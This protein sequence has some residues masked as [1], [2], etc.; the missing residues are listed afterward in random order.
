MIKIKN[1]SLKDAKPSDRPHFLICDTFNE[2]YLKEIACFNRAEII[3]YRE[4]LLDRIEPQDKFLLLHQHIDREI[5]IIRSIC[6]KS[7]YPV[8]IIQNLD[9]LITYLSS[10]PNSSL[11][12]FWNQLLKLRQLTKILWI[13]L[14]NKLVN[15]QIPEKRI[16]RIYL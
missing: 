15:P 4:N 10:H 7:D 1:V 11:S 6:C 2:L 13:I 3:D 14:P 8:V 12:I 9:Y 16:V 5:N